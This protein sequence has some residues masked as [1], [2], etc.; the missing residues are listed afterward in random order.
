MRRLNALLFGVVVMACGP[1]ATMRMT[2]PERDATIADSTLS[3]AVMYKGA[4][5]QRRPELVSQFHSEDFVY[6]W[7]GERADDEVH[8]AL[9][10]E[11]LFGLEEYGIE[12]IDPDVQVLGPDEAVVS[13]RYRHR[14]S[15]SSG[16][17]RESEGA[18]RYVFERRNRVWKIVRVVQ[19]GP[20]LAVPSEDASRAPAALETLPEGGLRYVGS[21]GQVGRGLV[22]ELENDA[23]ICPLPWFATPRGIEG[24]LPPGLSFDATYGRIEGT[25]EEVGTWTVG[26]VLDGVRCGGRPMDTI[27]VPVTFTIREPEQR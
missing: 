1:P 2:T 6:Y 14:E 10:G 8:A 20:V 27:T 11:A 12:M 17:V 13:F 24:D 21:D 5:E 15:N 4:W 25:P 23:E 7:N 19:S 18:M 16:S 9:H 26:V 3:M 22:A